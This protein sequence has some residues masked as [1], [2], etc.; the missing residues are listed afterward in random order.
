MPAAS[1]L[2]SLGDKQRLKSLSIRGTKYILLFCVPPAVFLAATSE[3]TLK[4]W[5]GPEFALHGSAAMLPLVIGVFFQGIITVQSMIIVGA[6]KIRLLTIATTIGGVISA[7]LCLALTKPFGICGSATAFAFGATAIAIPVFIH[8][9]RISCVTIMEIMRAAF[10]KPFIASIINYFFLIAFKHMVGNIID[11]IILAAASIVIYAA[12][13]LAL[14][15][16]GKD[17]I[18]ALRNFFPRN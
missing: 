2:I 8:G 14:K 11:L 6:G 3:L 18:S 16:I 17:D 5:M 15:A 10:L 9:C 13:L 7:I 12:S 1:E 4:I